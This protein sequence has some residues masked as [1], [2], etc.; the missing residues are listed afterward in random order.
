MKPEE[1]HKSGFLTKQGKNIRSWKTRFFI[2][3]EGKLVYKLD[4]KK[5]S[6]I[7]LANSYI[8]LNDEKYREYCFELVTPSRTYY[9]GCS[10]RYEMLE[11]I[12]CIQLATP[13]NAKKAENNQTDYSSTIPQKLFRDNPLSL[14]T[15]QELIYKSSCRLVTPM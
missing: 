10:T 13:P 5:S 11:W 12:R 14:T 7:P 15:A 8:Q 1:F 6:T 2:L 9:L 4:G 3:S